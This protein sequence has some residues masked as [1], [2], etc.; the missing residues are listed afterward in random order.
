MILTN[1]T[2]HNPPKKLSTSFPYFLLNLHHLLLISHHHPSPP[3]DHHFHHNSHSHTLLLLP[4]HSLSHPHHLNLCLRLSCFLRLLCCPYPSQQVVNPMKLLH[5]FDAHNLWT[6]FYPFSISPINITHL[7]SLPSN[8]YTFLKI[9][10]FPSI[11]LLMILHNIFVFFSTILLASVCWS[12][13]EEI[14]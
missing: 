10:Q 7:F 13:M 12:L 1:K 3:H 11:D 5:S 4:S 2:K 14:L 8:T 6:F 9:S